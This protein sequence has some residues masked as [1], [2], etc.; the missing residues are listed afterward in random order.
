MKVMLI[1]S[2]GGHLSELKKIY[3]YNDENNIIITEKTNKEIKR[4]NV[5]YL[6]Y[7]S[8]NN[9]FKYPFIFLY[10]SYLSLKYLRKYQPDIIVSTGAHSCVSFFWLAKFFKIKTIYIESF[11]R[12]NSSSLTYKLIKN[13]IDILIV[14]HKEMLEIYPNAI[15]LGSVY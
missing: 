13:K 5:D 8:R 3:L 9:K 4:K 7:G 1:A 11:A 2:S 12:V 10:N 14:Q 6:I 15:Y